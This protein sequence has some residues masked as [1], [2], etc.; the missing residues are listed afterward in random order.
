MGCARGGRRQTIGS[1]LKGKKVGMK[2][3]LIVP[4]WLKE[5]F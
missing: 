3:T 1:I 2:I 4:R 5:G